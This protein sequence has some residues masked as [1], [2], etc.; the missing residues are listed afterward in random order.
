[1]ETET[2]TET[3]PDMETETK[4]ETNTVSTADDDTEV[5]DE[6]SSLVPT[7]EL[8][9]TVPTNSNNPKQVKRVLMDESL[10]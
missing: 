9:V 10:D 5:E 3:N 2:K 7:E 4:T 8:T 6:P 1:M